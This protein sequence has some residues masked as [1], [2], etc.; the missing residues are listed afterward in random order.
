MKT[1]LFIRICGWIVAAVLTCGLSASC[2]L[3]KILGDVEDIVDG[4][5]EVYGWS[6]SGNKM[7]FTANFVV[8]TLTMEWT[9]GSDDKCTSAKS[10]VK[11]SSTELAN[12]YWDE[13]TADE[14]EKVTRNGNTVTEDLTEE[15]LGVDKATIR[16]T[17]EYLGE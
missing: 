5:G 7:T 14:K 4:D 12:A 3:A 2:N 17:F 13:L 10:S 15:Y 1:K 11:W 8:Y 6:E 16:E 9:F